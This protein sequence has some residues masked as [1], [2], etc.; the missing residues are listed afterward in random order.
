MIIW[1][2]IAGVVSFLLTLVCVPLFIRFL[3]RAQVGGQEMQEEV[4]QHVEKAGT[5][6]MGGFV[7]VGISVIVSIVLSIISKF[8]HTNFSVVLLV[9]VLYAGIG[10]FDDFLK[11][12]RHKNEGFKA[13]QKFSLQVVIG[14]VAYLLLAEGFPKGVGGSINFFGFTLT[15]GIFFI[16]F[17]ILW[18]VGWSNAVN[19]T[20]GIDGLAAGTVSIS[21]VAYAIIAYAQK[22]ADIFLI[23]L[24]VLGSL[25]AFLIFNKKPALIFMGDVGSLALGAF[26]AA[27]SVVL[28]AEW[29]LLFIG[30]I[31]AIETLSIMIQ[32]S[33]FKISGGKRVFR[34]SPIHHHLELGGLSGQDE[35]WSEIQIDHVFW[36]VT[37]LSSALAVVL[38]LIF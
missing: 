30:V 22:A 15:L 11:V 27:I 17:L 12:F 13:W 7:F 24:V 4:T 6:T 1:G 25:L 18:L 23:I 19:L 2:L 9:F 35:G 29:T 31:Y 10:F 36:T 32:V 3:K 8:H 5:P 20:D 33:Y 26:L 16:P 21:L 37:A 14:I 28:H 38:S 34:M